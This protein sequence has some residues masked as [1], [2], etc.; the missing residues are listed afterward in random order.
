M[1]AVAVN[2]LAL[3]TPVAENDPYTSQGSAAAAIQFQNSSPFVLLILAGGEQY[4]IQ[5]FTAQTLEL[6]G[7]GQPVQITPT[8]NPTGSA[9]STSITIV[10]LLP[11]EAAPMSDGPLTAAAIAAAITGSLVTAGSATLLAT[12]TEQSLAGQFDINYSGPIPETT[13]SMVA[14]IQPTTL[15]GP[16]T[17]ITNASALG[18]PSQEDWMI[19]AGIIGVQASAA[20][21]AFIFP[22]YAAIDTQ[23]S[24]NFQTN[25]FADN[26]SQWE[27]WLLALPDPILQGA[28]GNPLAVTQAAP[29]TAHTAVEVSAPSGA[30]TTVIPAPPAGQMTEV[31]A[32][33]FSTGNTTTVPATVR[34]ILSGGGGYVCAGSGPMGASLQAQFN[35]RFYTAQA[36]QCANASGATQ[37]AFATYRTLPK[38]SI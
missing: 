26:T 36:L 34:I 12:G 17:E 30:T 13:R 24:I 35:G 28:S 22:F 20:I 23:V 11:G 33:G 4:T 15:A 27:Y 37:N 6:A 18:V 29:N 8:T 31:I 3:G 1:D 10:W 32:C 9:A 16:T 7:G 21:P 38:G 5:G 2:G 14:I 25:N 19:F